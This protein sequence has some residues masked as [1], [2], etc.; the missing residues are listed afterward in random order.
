VALILVVSSLQFSIFVA[1]VLLSITVALWLLVLLSEK[2]RP[3]AP[4][5]MLAL[6]VYAGITLVSAV[7]SADPGTSLTDCKQL[8]LLLIVPITYDLM[9]RRL[10]WPAATA[11]MSAGA[12][13]GLLGIAQFGLLDYDNLGLRPRGTLGM[14]MTFSG[15]TMLVVGLALSQV[16][17]ARK[18]RTWPALIVPALSVAL[19][20]TFTRS[21]WV[22]TIAGLSLL[23]A[24][25]DYRL[26][27]IVPI[28]AVVFLLAAPPTVVQRFYSMFD[29]ADATRRDRVEMIEVGGHIVRAHPL[30]GVGPDMVEREYPAYRATGAMLETTPHLHNVPIQI[31]AER[32]L[33]AL[34]VWLWFIAVLVFDLWQLFRSK[35]EAWVPAAGLAAVVAM[36][37]AGQFEYNFGDSEFQMLFLFLITLPFAVERHP[38]ERHP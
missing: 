8:V 32:G 7:L 15:L 24:L 37:A 1:Q 30:T 31:A 21:A 13:S 9:T 22:G 14:Y 3:E 17:F 2:R 34:A 5:F 12:V 16:L 36:L 33:P 19:A 26:L 35:V 18:G 38:V 28:V 23:L 25:K 27:T 11:V 29:P 20:V 10:A 4:R 6:G